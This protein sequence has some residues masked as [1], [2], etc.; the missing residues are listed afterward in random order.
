MKK[1]FVY[2]LY[3]EKIDAFYRGQTNSIKD[4]LK[5]HNTGSNKSTLP[6][7]PWTLVW[8]IDKPNRSE[9]IGLEAKLKNMDR[10]KL[11]VFMKK[12]SEGIAGPDALILM[13][14]WS[15]C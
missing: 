9:A 8:F 12:Y 1:Y 7:I 11:I 2:V 5:R 15:G 14:Q 4:R 10:N 6:G 13:D 3:S